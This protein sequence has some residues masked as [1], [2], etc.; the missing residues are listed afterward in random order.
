LPT[1]WLNTNI[2]VNNIATL[3]HIYTDTHICIT[4]TLL[5]IPFFI[6]LPLPWAGRLTQTLLVSHNYENEI[7]K[8]EDEKKGKL[9]KKFKNKNQGNKNKGKKCVRKK[10]WH[11][12]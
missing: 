1:G 11:F 9:N 7:E 2:Q 5:F 8:R 12:F 3:H 6:L 10:T 4:F